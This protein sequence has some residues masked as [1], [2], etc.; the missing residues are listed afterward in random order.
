VSFVPCFFGFV[1]LT[2]AAVDS[3][4][5]TYAAVTAFSF[6]FPGS[7]MRLCSSFDYQRCPESL[8]LRWAYGSSPVSAMFIE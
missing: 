2:Y 6:A 3:K 1:S 8:L 5:K 4:K 7:V